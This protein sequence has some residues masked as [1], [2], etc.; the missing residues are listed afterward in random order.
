MLSKIY[1]H[2][3]FKNTL[4]LG[5]IK[6]LDILLPL[7]TIPY[8][9]RIL[10]VD[11]FGL[12]II[13]ISIYNL[14]NILTD[15]GFGLSTPYKI[16]QNRNNKFFLNYYLSGIFILKLFLF[17]TSVLCIT[18]YYQSADILS[19]NLTSM[20]ITYAIVFSLTFQVPWFFIGIEKMKVI[21]FLASTSKLI[22][23]LVIFTI[24]PLFKNIESV[25]L[26]IFFS[27]L[28]ASICY[29][30]LI[31]KEGIKFRLV[32]AKDLRE[33]FKENFGFFLSRVSVSLST[34]LNGILIGTILGNTSAAIYGAADKLYSAGIGLMSP[35][36][37]A[38]YPYMARTKNLRLLIIITI[39]LLLSSIIFCLFL[40]NYTVPLFFSIFGNEYVSSS[41]YFNLM[42]I[43]VPINI[44]SIL[45][46]YTAFSIVDRPHITNYTVIISSIVYILS[47]F[48]LYFF[49]RITINNIIYMVIFIDSIT[50]LLRLFLFFRLY[51]RK[52]SK[53]VK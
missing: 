18:L 32:A 15:F 53:S 26:S 36:S 9:T 37:N 48:I 34:T 10:T 20:L 28:I 30:I 1:K 6:L 21:T 33:L 50:L 11:D 52:G 13:S 41:N 44:T 42:L 31:Y 39:S 51:S 16:A 46:G 23:F 29:I 5:L 17:I 4:A 7:L 45:F 43:L 38:L 49:N 40:S 3:I 12:L 22:Y 8:L 19:K 14:A 47:F 35:I 24:V 25:L 27:N 2:S